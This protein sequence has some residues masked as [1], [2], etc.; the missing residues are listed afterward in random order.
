[1]EQR[2][3]WEANSFSA[4]QEI[5]RIL[6]NPEVHYRI[7]NS[8]PPV[9]ILIQL[10][11]VHAPS[12]FLKIHFNIILPSMPG[13]PK[14]SPSLRSPHQNPVCTSLFPHTCYLPRPSHSSRFDYPNNIWWLVQV[15]KDSA[16][17]DGNRFWLRVSCREQLTGRVYLKAVNVRQRAVCRILTLSN[18]YMLRRSQLGIGR[19]C[20]LPPRCSW[21]P[22]SSGM[23]RGVGWEVVTGVSGQPM[24]L[25]GHENPFLLA[26]PNDLSPNK[27]PNGRSLYSS[28][29]F[30]WYIANSTA[31]LHAF[32]QQNPKNQR[33]CT[34]SWASSSPHS[35]NQFSKT[36]TPIGLSASIFPAAILQ[37]FTTKLERESS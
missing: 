16:L 37:D 22:R 35:H 30:L 32:W 19:D 5:P 24:G 11:P 20:R 23:L 1:M 9:P 29:K 2:P 25:A 31:H 10:N 34:G 21:G 7:H 14:W 28:P 6:W 36:D 26:L 15:I 12:H 13:S 33:R 27:A 3:S 18:Y 17:K 8:P 4:S